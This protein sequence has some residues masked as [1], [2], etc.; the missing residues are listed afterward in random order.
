MTAIAVAEL[1]SKLSPTLTSMQGMQRDKNDHIKGVTAEQRI[2]AE[3]K[4]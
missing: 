2:L 1:D 3:K 4:L